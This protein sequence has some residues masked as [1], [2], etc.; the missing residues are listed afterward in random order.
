MIQNGTVTSHNKTWP[1]YEREAFK[2]EIVGTI[3][4]D[5]IFEH[6]LRSLFEMTRLRELG[7]EVVISKVRNLH[8]SPEDQAEKNRLDA[9]AIN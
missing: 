7:V 2:V 4:A 5:L 6:S 3:D 8:L 1:L 9:A